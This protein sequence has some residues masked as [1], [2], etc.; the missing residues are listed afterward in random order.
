MIM[1]IA[2]ATSTKGN[3]AAAI[4]DAYAQLCT[5]LGGPPHWAFLGLSALHDVAD[6]QRTWRE[7]TDAPLHAL[8]SSGGTMTQEGVFLGRVMSLF[9]IR[10]DRGAYGV[11]AAEMTADPK[12]AAQ[13]ATLAALEHAGRPGQLPGIVWLSCSPGHEEGVIEG[14]EELIGDGVPIV[15]GSCADEEIA[16]RWSLFDRDL[17]TQ[18]GVAISV[19]FPSMGHATL[20]Q[21]GFQPTEHTGIVTRAEGRILHELDGRPAA[22]V[23]DEWTGGVIA[24]E[25]EAGA[26]NI[27]SQ[28]SLSP[29]GRIVSSMEGKD[30]YLL[31][32]PASV[33]GGALSLFTDVA[34]GERFT[35]M[36]GSANRLIERAGRMAKQVQLMHDVSSARVLGSLVIFCAGC[37]MNVSDRLDE[38]VGG[39]NDGLDERPFLGTFTFGEQGR[40]LDGG[41]RHGNLM[42]T[43]LLFFDREPAG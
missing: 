2:T 27:L 35:C 3:S 13:D 14:I 1:P 15:G 41:S 38:V 25:R 7:L 9:G 32:H 8:T 16:G 4:R 43:V 37:M 20:F 19:L 18:D 6:V 17:L 33:E 36:T 29:L 31:S 26:G 24:A 42:L 23:Y 22:Q 30:Y 11:G 40:M 39:L 12:Q 34:E 28:S 21:G 5:R 10:D